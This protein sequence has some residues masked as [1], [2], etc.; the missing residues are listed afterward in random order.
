L[1]ALSE[2]V[3]TSLKNKNYENYLMRLDGVLKHYD[4]MNINYSK[5]NLK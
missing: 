2:A 3:W 4:A 1:A 5:S